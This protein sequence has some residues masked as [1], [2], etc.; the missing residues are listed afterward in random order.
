MLITVGWGVVPIVVG[1]ISDIG[2]AWIFSVDWTEG[3]SDLKVNEPNG[4]TGLLLLILEVLLFTGIF[5]VGAI[6]LGV[7]TSFLIVNE[8]TWGIGLFVTML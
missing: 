7:S 8:G 3:K 4:S 2:W 1:N 6:I 5:V